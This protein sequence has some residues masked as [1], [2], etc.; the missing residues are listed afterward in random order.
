MHS[1]TPDPAPSRRDA[2]KTLSAAAGAALLTGGAR[3]DASTGSARTASGAHAGRDDGYLLG[4]GVIYL[5]HA[6]IG[7]APARVLAARDELARAVEANP[8]LHVWA[9][10][11]DERIAEARRT[12]A[13]YLG[14]EPRRLAMVRTTTDAMN[15]LAQ[16]LG[17]GPGDE[18]LCSSLNHV[19]ATACFEHH[20]RRRGY[21]VRRFDFPVL[22]APSL[23]PGD[24]VRIYADQIRDNTRLL[25]FP[26][27]DNIIGLRYPVRALAVEARRRG[28]EFVA[29]DGAQA[30]GMMPV[31]VDALGVDFYAISA[32]KWLQSPKAVGLAVFTDTLIERVEPMVVTWGQNSWDDARRFEDWGTHDPAAWPVLREAVEHQA[33]LGTPGALFERRMAL[34]ARVRERCASNAGFWYRSPGHPDLGTPI[35]AVEVEGIPSAEV[36]DRLRRRGYVF[37]AFRE[38]GLDTCRVSVNAM[39]TAAEIDGFFAH[40][41]G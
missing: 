35:A 40:A 23:T 31:E 24:V 5:N 25:V 16:G 20:G 17:L 7:T 15:T 6:S 10:A 39:N 11:W 32:H 26:H 37:R 1:R 12:V 9:G 28:V 21:T 19:G 30:A 18:V 41:R 38:Q 34:R 8:W 36:F 33:S 14:T 27:V 29:C 22:D 4:D 2:I 13:A 3:A